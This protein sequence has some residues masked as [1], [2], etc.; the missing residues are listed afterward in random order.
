M[1]AIGT[2]AAEQL[3][4][5][6]A[7]VGITRAQV[8][9]IVGLRED[10]IEVMS[11]ADR[12]KVEVAIADARDRRQ[13]IDQFVAQCVEHYGKTETQARTAAEKATSAK[14]R[15]A[16]AA[17][18]ADLRRRGID[19]RTAAEKSA[20]RQAA[21]QRQE[22]RCTSPQA[23]QI[24]DL[25]ARRVRSGEGGGFMS[26]AGLIDGQGQIDMKAIR[27]LPHSAASAMI[28]SLRGDY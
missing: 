8:A 4:A 27:G 18:V 6:A 5:A 15:Q 26:T 3:T 17:N 13:L 25:L 11:G 21:A 10:A 1:T 28:D 12:R 20:D 16:I 7:E 14:L 19:P 22:A 2:A 23:E 24:G 9:E